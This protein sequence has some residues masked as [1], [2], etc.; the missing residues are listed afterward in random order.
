MALILDTG[1]LLA[2][3]DRN[4]PDHERCSSL[5]RSSREDLVVPMLVLAEVDD[6]CHQRLGAQARLSFLEDVLAGAYRLEAPTTSDLDRCRALQST[7]VDL[8]LGVVDAS[9]MVLCERLGEPKVGTLDLRHF[10][11]VR[12]SHVEALQL[13]PK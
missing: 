10:S 1:P 6:W 7:S 8:K 13:L 12:L 2:A 3:L 9:V 11:V 4:D 5:I